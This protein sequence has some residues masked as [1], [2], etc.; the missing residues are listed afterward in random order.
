MRRLAWHISKRLIAFGK[1]TVY[2]LFAGIIGAFAE[3]F[4]GAYRV[5]AFAVGLPFLAVYAADIFGVKVI[6]GGK[7]VG[8]IIISHRCLGLTLG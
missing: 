7:S 3:V 4:D 8:G 1:H 5:A 2:T 6:G